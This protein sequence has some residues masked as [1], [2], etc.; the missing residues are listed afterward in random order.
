VSRFASFSTELLSWC[1]SASL[2][3]ANFAKLGGLEEKCVYF[4]VAREIIQKVYIYD[5]DE[6]TNFLPPPCTQRWSCECRPWH[7]RRLLFQQHNKKAPDLLRSAHFSGQNSWRAAPPRGASDTGCIVSLAGGSFWIENLITVHV[8][9]SSDDNKNPLERI[10][11][12]ILTKFDV[13]C[14]PCGVYIHTKN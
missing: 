6:E 1:S 13:K 2:L 3:V 5:V 10:L 12:S 11:I 4:V 14:S 7:F 8:R 9:K